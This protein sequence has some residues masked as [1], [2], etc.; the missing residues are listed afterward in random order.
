MRE[1]FYSSN[2][3]FTPSLQSVHFYCCAAAAGWRPGGADAT[4]D[5]GCCSA[6][7]YRKHVKG[8]L[9]TYNVRHWHW[10]LP[11]S[12]WPVCQQC[13]IA[14]KLE[15]PSRGENIKGI[16]S[17]LKDTTSIQ[18]GQYYLQKAFKQEKA[19]DGNAMHSSK[20]RP[21][22]DVGIQW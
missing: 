17:D 2:V 8:H 11:A 22:K 18:K 14:R 15:K 4:A 7:Q 6:Q 12:A 10:D 3:I 20:C 19:D 9:S 13:H 1:R 21:N 16:H 5:F